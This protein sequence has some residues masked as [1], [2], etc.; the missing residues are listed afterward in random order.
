MNSHGFT[1]I[2]LLIV[3]T[4]VGILSLL[5]GQ[6]LQGNL[7]AARVDGDLVEF[8]ADLANARARAIHRGHLYFVTVNTAAGTYQITEDTN[9]NGLLEG[10]P[11]T[12]LFLTPKQL[13][14]DPV[15]DPVTWAGGQIVM[16]TRGFIAP[17]GTLQVTPTYLNPN[18]DCIQLSATAINI[19]LMNGGNCAIK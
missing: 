13:T 12:P 19:G 10:A 7:G 14:Q 15:A 11:D 5:L 18:Y 9:D 8:Q 4:I 1:L 17:T 16:N 6:S 3:V 2:Q